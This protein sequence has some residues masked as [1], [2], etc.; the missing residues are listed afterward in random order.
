MNALVQLKQ[1]KLP[2]R[3]IRLSRIL[4][5]KEI[6]LRWQRIAGKKNPEKLVRF[7]ANLTC[8]HVGVNM[9]ETYE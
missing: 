9:C 6:R 7:C 8:L 5:V 3:L 1:P 4:R 2:K